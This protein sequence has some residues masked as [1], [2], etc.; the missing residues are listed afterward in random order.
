GLGL[1]A[2]LSG[3]ISTDGACSLP[4]VGC[5]CEREIRRAMSFRLPRLTEDAEIVTANRRPSFR[6][7][8]WWQSIVT[9]LEGQENT[10][11]DILVQ[12]QQAQADIVT[13]LNQAGIALDL[14]GAVM[15]DIPPV[16]IL[17]DYTG[18]VLD[19][20]LPRD[21]QAQRFSGDDDVTADADWSATTLSGG[22]TY[23]MGTGVLNVTAITSS[24]VVEIT[25]EYNGIPRSRKLPITLQLQDP[26][27]SSGAT[28]EYDSS[29]DPTSSTS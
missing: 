11:D 25:S 7:Q 17:A 19:G 18:T 3:G 5:A 20:Q 29:I 21:I 2:R 16:T 26:P 15:P 10:Q 14:A 1:P 22:V 27:P 28:T 23:T 24:A 9:K 4:G 6:F 8:R 13:A 12:L